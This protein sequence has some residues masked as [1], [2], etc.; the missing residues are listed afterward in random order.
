MKDEILLVCRDG[1]GKEIARQKFEAAEKDR[2]DRIMIARNRAEIS[3]NSECR[4]GTE[5]ETPVFGEP[6]D[7]EFEPR[8]HNDADGVETM[9]DQ[10]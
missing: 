7:R 1:N 5:T 2:C 3:A 9:R 10:G 6:A 4:W 8:D